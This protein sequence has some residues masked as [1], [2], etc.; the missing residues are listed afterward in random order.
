MKVINDA[1]YREQLISNGFENRK[2][3]DN[4]RI[5]SQY[6]AVYE[7]IMRNEP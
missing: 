7:S 6:A 3:F 5:A 4:D 1:T 2:R